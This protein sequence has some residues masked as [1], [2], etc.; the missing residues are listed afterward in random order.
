M[1]L[2]DFVKIAVAGYIGWDFIQYFRSGT[3][4][5]HFTVFF[6]W[7]LQDWLIALIVAIATLAVVI[8][9]VTVL[10]EIKP[11]QFS[12]LQLLATEK[13]KSTAGT[14]LIASGVKLPYIGAVF[15]VLLML[16]VPR[17]ARREEEV[18]RRGSKDWKDIAVR[19]TKF[20]FLHMLVGVPVAGAIALIF[21]GLALTVQ[22]KIGGVRRATFYH[23]LNNYIV[24]SALGIYLI[25]K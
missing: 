15:G 14:N 1:T 4:K 18:F 19:S 24:L 13:E 21:L 12:W 2:L 11:L 5:R 23:C 25:L 7:K 17:L 10:Y 22:Y 9:L 6:R 8:G 3:L 20:G 16:N